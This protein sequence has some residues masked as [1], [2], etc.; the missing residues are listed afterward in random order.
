MKLL[1]IAL[2]A[3]IASVGVALLV[4]KDPGY[5][6]L[7][8]REWTL[9]STLSL[10]VVAL[11]VMF[12]VFHY[13]LRLLQ[14]MQRMPSRVGRWRRRRHQRQA[15]EGLDLAQLAL[16]EG[17]WK[18]AEQQFL[19]HA[20]HSD[21]PALNYLGAAEAAQALHAA[22]RRDRYLQ[23]AREKTERAEMAVALT[24]AELQMREGQWE[25]ALATL[26]QLH[27]LE[28]K[29]LRV[30]QLLQ[31]VHLQIGDWEALHRLLPELRKAK[32]LS[33]EELQALD[34]RVEL[35]RLRQAA[36]AQDLPRMRR[37]WRGLPNA[38]RERPEVIG[39]YAISLWELDASSEA[40]SLLRMNLRSQWDERL[41]LLYG[42]MEGRDP[43]SQL[44][45]AERW[46]QEHG[47]DPIL[48]LTLGRLAIRNRQW[49]K[50]RAY[51]EASIGLGARPEAYKEL[52]A[53]LEHLGDREAAINCYR[54][55]MALAV[56]QRAPH[57]PAP[58]E[59]DVSRPILP[60]NKPESEQSA[61]QGT[62][63]A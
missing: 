33:P 62:P 8:Y 5:V 59:G 12:L 41:V 45:E 39:D 23:E 47:R 44:E 26:T 38:T 7:A 3:L 55:G 13:L 18:T 58:L 46:E 48:L 53:L 28:R 17:R 27:N 37:I 60:A 35:A 32:L 9:E 40:E 54:S 56:R 31:Q 52:A 1:F 20:K 50:A 10:A 43:L 16:A 42:L 24:R 21:T 2:A 19:R 14:G 49:D 30:L 57:L 11:L 22:D 29:N 34:E 6:L 61:E 51:L 25:Q 15:R 4:V 63:A 36:A